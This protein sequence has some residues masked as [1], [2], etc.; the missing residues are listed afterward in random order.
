M[1]WGQ[2]PAEGGEGWLEVGLGGRPELGEKVGGVLVG[3][4]IDVA[5]DDWEEVVAGDGV[6]FLDADEVAGGG[7]GGACDGEGDLV[8]ASEGGHGGF[9]GGGV[10]AGDG[11]VGV[12]GEAGGAFEDVLV[13][14]GHWVVSGRGYFSASIG[15]A[16]R[17]RIAML[18]CGC[19]KKY[20]LGAGAVFAVA[21]LVYGGIAYAANTQGSPDGDGV[22]GSETV[23]EVAMG[24]KYVLGYEFEMIDGTTRSLEEFKG[25]VVMMVNVAS[26]CGLTPQYEGLEALYRKHKDAGLVV[27]GFPAN[28]FGGQEPG[29]NAEIAQFCSTKFDV[30]FPM[31]GKIVVKGEGIH[32]LYQQLISQPDPVGG[33][34]EW[35]FDKFLVDRDG[36]VVGRFKPR[37]TPDD[38]ELVG[39][40]ERLLGEE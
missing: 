25:S 31:T 34:I 13:W 38:G 1:V 21:V 8:V 36:E 4:G 35:N 33:E 32:P 15:G 17:M 27:I 24:S 22:V 5:G 12:D 14:Y 30:S 18:T 26:E 20:G 7:V 29:T 11:G 16:G 6:E 9:A 3:V 2:V 28:E 10:E 39:M 19:G 37:T 23:Q 40:V